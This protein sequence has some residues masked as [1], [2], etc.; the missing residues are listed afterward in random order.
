MWSQGFASKSVG[1]V[2]GA[3]FVGRGHECCTADV[4]DHWLVF[5]GCG[6]LMPVVARGQERWARLLH[7]VEG[8]HRGRGLG[9]QK[10]PRRCAFRADAI[11][12]DLE[13]PETLTNGLRRQLSFCRDL[14]EAFV[15]GGPS[16]VRRFGAGEVWSG[17]SCLGAEGDERHTIVPGASPGTIALVRA[18]FK[19]TEQR[20][21]DQHRLQVC[22]CRRPAPRGTDLT[23]RCTSGLCSCGRQA[24]SLAS[25]Y[26]DN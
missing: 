9:V 26:S 22:R 25:R 2:S 16:P 11:L 7:Q 3:F 13:L 18:R 14:N 6:H 23:H 24:G 12:L 5:R 19:G 10:V 17:V 4:S 15:G 8:D 21:R 20:A 1:I